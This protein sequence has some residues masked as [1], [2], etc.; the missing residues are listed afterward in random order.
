MSEILQRSNLTVQDKQMI[1]EEITSNIPIFIGASDLKEAVKVAVENAV[2]KLPAE[3]KSKPL[4]R[5]SFAI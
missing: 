3:E 1:I 4:C 2:E 5:A